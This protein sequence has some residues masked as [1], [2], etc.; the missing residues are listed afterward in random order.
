MKELFERL[1]KSFLKKVVNNK[2]EEKKLIEK[3]EKKIRDFMSLSPNYLSF[4]EEL[5]KIK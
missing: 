3:F 4:M 1:R 2:C 5:K